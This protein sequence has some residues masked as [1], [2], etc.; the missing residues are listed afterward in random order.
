MFDKFINLDDTIYSAL[1]QPCSGAQAGLD[2]CSISIAIKD[3]FMGRGLY[4][5]IEEP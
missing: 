4:I 3:L 2:I 5:D 1:T